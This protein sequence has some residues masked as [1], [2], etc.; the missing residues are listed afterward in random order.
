MP[1]FGIRQMFE[2]GCP[3]WTS[4]TVLESGD[5]PLHIRGAQ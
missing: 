4:G 1:E 5:G 2:A 3:F